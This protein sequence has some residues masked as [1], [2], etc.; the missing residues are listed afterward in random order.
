MKRNKWVVLPW[1]PCFVTELLIP[2][3]TK[4]SILNGQFF[5]ILRLYLF[6]SAGALLQNVKLMVMLYVILYPFI[7]I[8]CV[9]AVFIHNQQ[10]AGVDL[11]VNQS[12]VIYA[13]KKQI[14]HF[15]SAAVWEYLTFPA[16]V[17]QCVMISAQS[18]F[19][20]GA[21][22]WMVCSWPPVC[23]SSLFLSPPSGQKSEFCQRKCKR[24][25]FWA[26][27]LVWYGKKTN[28]PVLMF[29]T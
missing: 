26:Y 10:M 29:S 8:A 20:A 25:L 9:H 2:Y 7:F 21:G 27:V 24:F 15:V 17:D 3:G 6:F 12:E 11:T 28:L 5:K 1:Y 16:V 4:S 14:S 13:G 22:T 18:L 23:E 19:K